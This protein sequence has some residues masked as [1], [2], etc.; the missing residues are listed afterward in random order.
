MQVLIFAV[1][2][3]VNTR[4]E[5]IDLIG[6]YDV[7]GATGVPVPVPVLRIVLKIQFGIEDEGMVH[8]FKIRIIDADGGAVL[9]EV[10]TP[11]VVPD[12]AVPE[13]Q[14]MVFHQEYEV[15]GVVFPKFGEYS[16]DLQ[17]VDG[18]TLQWPLRLVQQMDV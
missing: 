12:G 2:D 17:L 15:T 11:V 14:H 16:V 18:T 7:L 3:S 1:C 10:A 6:V 5:K 13:G 9:Q 8:H 4:H